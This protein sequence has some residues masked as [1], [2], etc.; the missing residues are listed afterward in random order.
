MLR[1]SKIELARRLAATVAIANDKTPIQALNI[2]IYG[3]LRYRKYGERYQK[4]I[5]NRDWLFMSEVL[6]LSE[7]AQCDLSS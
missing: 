1:I 6:D 2:L 4:A 5:A 7:Y 3:W